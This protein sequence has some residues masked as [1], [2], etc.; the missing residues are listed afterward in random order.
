MIPPVS[1]IV[2]A[3]HGDTTATLWQGQRY[4]SFS[5]QIRLRLSA[6]KFASQCVAGDDEVLNRGNDSIGKAPSPFLDFR[7]NLARALPAVVAAAGV[8]LSIQL[9]G[10]MFPSHDWAERIAMAAGAALLVPAFSVLAMFAA[11][12]FLCWVGRLEPDSHK[13][14]SVFDSKL[15]VSS[16]LAMTAL[17]VLNNYQD[18]RRF[19]RLAECA[20]IAQMSGEFASTR[21]RFVLEGCQE[22]ASDYG[23]E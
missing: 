12:H 11:Y 20:E 5:L 19:E 17:W 16:V 18:Q 1:S 2:P 4:D 6:A 13:A 14:E 7:R 3:T 23:D 22:P 10:D 8:Q 21:A 9:P 15:V